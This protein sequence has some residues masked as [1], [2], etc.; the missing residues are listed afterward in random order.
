MQMDIGRAFTFVGEDPKWVTKVLIGGGLL[1]LAIVLGITVIGAILIGAIV[2][3]YLVQLTRNV[4]AGERLPLPE[5][6]N[7]GELLVDGLKAW[8][9]SFVLAL[10]LIVVNS[11]VWVPA[12]IVAA[13]G[14][15]SDAG[16][17]IGGLLSLVGGCL[18]FL[19]GIAYALMLPVAIGRYAVTRSIAEGLRLGA[20]FATVRANIGTYLIVLLMIFAA[21][22]IGQLGILLCFI[23]L[24]FTLFY[25]Q[26]VQYHLYGQAHVKAHGSMPGMGQPQAAFPP[27]YPY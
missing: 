21:S 16:A 22:L 11:V 4:I 6:T 1:L 14:G 5:W 19:L 24:P 26:V 27:P 15:D 20:I 2:F 3:G 12:I 8:V 13:A 9:V 17:A 10:P 7:F 23:G 18:G 25:A